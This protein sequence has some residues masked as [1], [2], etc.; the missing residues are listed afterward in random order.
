MI[1]IQLNEEQL[2][3]MLQDAIRQALSGA[4]VPVE[5]IEPQGHIK[6][7]KGLSE[8][9]NVS[10]MKA[11]ELKNSGILP[12]FQSGRTILFDPIKVKEAMANYSKRD[13]R[14]K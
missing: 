4:P 9:L 1:I 12:Y 10:H 13:R 14:A 8:F 6:G 7:I 3:N 5:A 11:Q 2:K